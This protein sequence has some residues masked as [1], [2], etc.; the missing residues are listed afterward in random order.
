ME[1]NCDALAIMLW[2]RAYPDVDHLA[3]VEELYSDSL[4][5]HLRK[6]PHLDERDTHFDPDYTYKRAETIH[7]FLTQ[8]PVDAQKNTT[9]MT[10]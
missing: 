8:K 9:I 7:K 5:K 3:I 4:A 10:S 6:I 1:R 2:K